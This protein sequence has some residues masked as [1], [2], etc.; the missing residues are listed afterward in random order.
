MNRVMRQ[1]TVRAPVEKVFAFLSDPH[2]LPEIWP[3]VL[4]VKNIKRDT[5][6]GYNFDWAYKMSGVRLEGK[7]ETAEI[8][9]NQRLVF[10][11]AKGFECIFRWKFMPE[12]QLTN[13]TLELDYTIP[14]SVLK[15]AKEDVVTQLNE[16]EIEAL[17]E[18][19]RT[20]LELEI[21]YA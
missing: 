7:V 2:N 12:S 21:A 8:M 3:N 11:S 10:K 13:L 9:R 1:L 4:E 14:P 15:H 20:K 17:I 6:G 18:N 16:H 19:V 5:S